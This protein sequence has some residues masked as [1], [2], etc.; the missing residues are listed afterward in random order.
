MKFAHP[1]L[2][3]KNGK[4]EIYENGRKGQF[5]WIMGELNPSNTKYPTKDPKMNECM[6]STLNEDFDLRTFI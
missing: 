5:E 3:K 4:L 6:G 2:V 1:D